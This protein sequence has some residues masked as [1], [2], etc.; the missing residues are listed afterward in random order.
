[1]ESILGYTIGLIP[2]LRVKD[3]LKELPASFE[4][5]IQFWDYL[6]ENNLK[7]DFKLY[8]ELI[9]QVSLPGIPLPSSFPLDHFMDFLRRDTEQDKT[10]R[11][12]IQASITALNTILEFTYEVDREV[13]EIQIPEILEFLENSLLSLLDTVKY[14]GLRHAITKSNIPP[15]DLNFF[16]KSLTI[17]EMGLKNMIRLIEKPNFV[18]TIDKLSNDQLLDYYFE[19]NRS[20]THLSGLNPK[21]MLALIIWNATPK[22]NS[23]DYVIPEQVDITKLPSEFL[24]ELHQEMMKLDQEQLTFWDRITQTLGGNFTLDYY[25]ELENTAMMEEITQTKLNL[26]KKLQPEKKLLRFVYGDDALEFLFTILDKNFPDDV[27]IE[28]CLEE[29]EFD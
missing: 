17:L 1:M 5:G 24:L 22:P 2:S 19:F 8:F 11:K 13:Q 9:K 20:W 29:S 28:K 10:L 7:L 23:P 12:Q 16:Q 3:S 6:H 18:P 27:D 21:L 14:A 15:K 4:A 26:L 25:K